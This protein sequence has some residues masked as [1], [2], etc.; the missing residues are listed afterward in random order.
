MN[1]P[2]SA[3]ELANG[4]A[5]EVPEVVS[6]RATIGVPENDPFRKSSNKFSY[7]RQ[8]HVRPPWYGMRLLTGPRLDATAATCDGSS[9]YGRYCYGPVG[10]E[11]RAQTDGIQVY[12]AEIAAPGVLNLEWHNNY[13]FDGL[14]T[15]RFPGG[16]VPNHT[17]NSVPEWAYGV[18]DWFEQGLYLPLYSFSSNLGPVLD[19]FK[20]RELFVVPH[21]ADRTFFYGINF[22]FS[23][24]ARHWDPSIYS[25]EIRPIIGW[26][27]GKFDFI[28]NPIFD[29]SWKGFNNLDFAPATRIAYNLS[30]TWAVAVEEYADFGIIKHFLAPDQQL[31]QLFGVIDFKGE[32]FNIEAGL[33]F[34]LTSASDRLVAK[35]MLSRDLYKPVRSGN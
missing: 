26:H 17:F 18:T 23:Y 21:A 15:P 30:Q 25:S 24:N 10:R 13:T 20:L 27:L 5:L 2:N 12:D 3:G 1:L 6:R 34:G 22:E 33:G 19:G 8:R 9:T 35:V 31:H 32:P 29:N 4:S 28:V 7:L 11:T 14:K 16:L